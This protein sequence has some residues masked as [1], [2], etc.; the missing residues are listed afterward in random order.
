MTGYGKAESIQE[1]PGFR[2]SI[3]S[4]NSKN[5]EIRFNSYL[6]LHSM[7]VLLQNKIKSIAKRGRLFIDITEKSKAPIP[8]TLEI[9]EPLIENYIAAAKNI[10]RKYNI[11]GEIDVNNILNLKGIFIIKDPREIDSISQK[12]I[13][14]TLDKA[15]LE[16]NKS[17]SKEG[18]TTE[19]DIKES[20]SVIKSNYAVINKNRKYLKNK[21]I[22]DIKESLNKLNISNGINEK[23][24][25]EEISFQIIRLDINE[26]LKRL[27]SHLSNL[28]KE[29]KSDNID[30]GKKLEF[31]MQ[32]C[33]RESN[34][35]S[36]KINDANLSNYIIDIKAEFNKIKEH[37]RNIV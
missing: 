37:L 16:W 17:R 11:P 24:I 18:K 8:E 5:L 29:I 1:N 20:I 35:I 30:S 19:K 9:N 15:L 28:E 23:R 12:L 10:N 34:T 21:L 7:E 2:I 14:D 6:N 32:E 25:L 36:D 4:I 26:E 27:K 31:I 22:E 13:I 33:I 3:N